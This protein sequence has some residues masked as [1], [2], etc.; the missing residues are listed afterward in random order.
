ME[1]F[2][3]PRTKRAQV[4]HQGVAHEVPHGALPGEF[5]LENFF[6]GAPQ[7]S[8]KPTV[9]RSGKP[10]GKPP[11]V[12]LTPQK[13][14]LPGGKEQDLKVVPQYREHEKGPV[15]QLLGETKE[16]LDDIPPKKYQAIR[17]NN[18]PYEAISF[19]FQNR[20]AF[21]MVE[22]DHHFK[23]VPP[24]GKSYVV[25]DICSGPGGFS[26][27]VLTKLKWKAKVF[28]F[29]LRNEDDF[30]VDNFNVSSTTET[31]H[32]YYGPPV[33]E[34]TTYKTP[35]GQVVPNKLGDG[36][37]TSLENLQAFSR[38]IGEKVDLVVA[39]GGFEISDYNKQE[40]FARKMLLGEFITPLMILKEG[41]DFA[42]K[43]FTTFTEFSYD[44]LFLASCLYNEVYFVK[45]ISS[46]VANSERF[47][48][49]KGF[50]GISRELLGKLQNLLL[51]EG[52]VPE[53]STQAAA[54]PDSFLDHTSSAWKEFRKELDRV[55]TVVTKTQV[56][57]LK[58]II[59]VAG[60]RRD[61]DAEAE[62]VTLQEEIAEKVSKMVKIHRDPRLDSPPG[63]LQYSPL[64]G[65][66]LADPKVALEE[67]SRSEASSEAPRE[68][69]SEASSEAPLF[70]IKT[71][72]GKRP[73]AQ[74]LYFLQNGKVT[75]PFG[76]LQ[77]GL[78]A[79]LP[80][81][82]IVEL[83]RDEESG[84]LAMVRVVY[85]YLPEGY[86]GETAADYA[87]LVKNA[88]LP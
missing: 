65:Q 46:R 15:E 82:S 37:I 33:P 86:R 55:N 40:I 27:Y 4:A 30:R 17:N 67:I 25:A 88:E 23:L 26:E 28:G 60:R 50:R 75:K 1:S 54:V 87:L 56:F 44:L 10:T 81:D 58:K 19:F 20:A 8:G 84:T 72:F 49:C 7:R 73:R 24:A 32:A 9:V 29:T 34:G 48:V 51:L 42:C 52:E 59:W 31:F 2:K 5:S 76:E 21:K 66:G 80:F 70:L 57:H 3:I 53:G 69:R 38:R 41:G 63:Y 47:L 16:K 39:D 22:L 79:S 11:G 68:A 35:G 64:Y 85:S 12:S 14:L 36:D 6:G 13:F 45:P 78:V 61:P 71:G 43:L 18:N 62:N 83:E 77:R 74:N